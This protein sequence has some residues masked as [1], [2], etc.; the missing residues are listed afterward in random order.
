MVS[1]PPSAAA[2]AAP[3]TG[4]AAQADIDELLQGIDLP[5]TT[6]GIMQLVMLQKFYKKL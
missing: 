2:A 1:N 3:S 4:L 6:A 5:S